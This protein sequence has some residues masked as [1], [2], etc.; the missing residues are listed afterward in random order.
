MTS[1]SFYAGEHWC[2]SDW[3]Y[4]VTGEAAAANKDPTVLLVDP[5]ID[6]E[7]ALHFG[8]TILHLFFKL[9]PQ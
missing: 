6:E 7:P 1:A 2:G 4:F 5:R 8:S 9:G 3:I